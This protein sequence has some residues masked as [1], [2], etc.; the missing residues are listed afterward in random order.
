[1]VGT[2]A[3][4]PSLAKLLLLLSAR[5]RRLGPSYRVVSPLSPADGTMQVGN[6]RGR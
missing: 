5:D 4:A 6:G 3:N 1:M 2:N